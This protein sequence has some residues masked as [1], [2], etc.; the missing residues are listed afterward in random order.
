MT[1]FL[2][3]TA[4]I[5]FVER[6]SKGNP[7]LDIYGDPIYNPNTVIKKCRRERSTK[8]VLTT[9][10]SAVLSTTKYFFDNSVTLDIGDKVDGKVIL[11]VEDFINDLGYSEGWMVTV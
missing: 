1:K 7:R 2:K 6:D 5:T 10:G 8:D 3:Q 4:E 11:T 9:G